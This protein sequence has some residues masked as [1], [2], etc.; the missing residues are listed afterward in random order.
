ME[1]GWSLGFVR[2]GR[3]GFDGTGTSDDAVIAIQPASC[4][5][6][7]MAQKDHPAIHTR[8]TVYRR[9]PNP[10]GTV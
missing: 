10:L 7:R 4:V 9:Q 1:R 5:G 3:S 6:G 2:V 8:I